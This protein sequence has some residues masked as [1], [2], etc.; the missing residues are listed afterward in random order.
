MKIFINA[1]A[2]KVAGGKS[3]LSNFLKAISKEG[4]GHTYYVFLPD[5]PI[6][7][8]FRTVPHM[9]M[10][11]TP[12][13]FNKP[14]FRYFIDHIYLP[15]KIRS[16]KPDAVF[17]MGNVSLPISTAP[18]ILLFH[19]PHPLYPD[20]AYWQ[21]IGMRKK[22][23]DF[24][25]SQITRKFKYAS[26]IA[27]QTEAAKVRLEKYYG[28][29][30][31]TV[32]I[33]NAVSLNNM[34]QV[35]S[36]PAPN[37][38]QLKQQLGDAKVFL[39]LSRYYEHKNIE[40]LVDVAERLKAEGTH[41]KI[42]ITIDHNQGKGAQQI[43]NSIEEKGLSDVIINAGNVRMDDIRHIY[44]MSDA[45]ILPTLLESFSGTYVEAAYFRK[46]V[47]T[48]DYDFAK[49]ILQENAFYFDPLDAEDIA[50]KLGSIEDRPLIE[51]VCAGAFDRIQQY[52][53]WSSV[54][55]SYLTLIENTT[56][57]YV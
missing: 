3:V 19:M 10:F 24:L 8:E 32:V 14:Y 45:L 57:Q 55:A 36:T 20:S 28:L 41:Y 34:R 52:P 18:Q 9:H 22:Y 25:I 43:L 54:A 48:S 12:N 7:H 17:S 21:R 6:Y 53:D 35:N 29:G 37:L 23:F 26:V 31:K 13:F 47:F 51:K 44:E 33:P 42:L 50:S 49:E 5:D 4:R 2:L 39:C 38:L 40:V 46:P 15:A 16:I 1:V 56:K 30:T 27:A 11:P